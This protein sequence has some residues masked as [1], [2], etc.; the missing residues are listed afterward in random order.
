MERMGKTT[1]PT[2]IYFVTQYH[3]PVVHNMNIQGYGGH[4]FHIFE[5]NYSGQ[6]G[7]K[8]TA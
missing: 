6:T 4:K 7:H 5:A 3:N 1:E 8:F 2:K